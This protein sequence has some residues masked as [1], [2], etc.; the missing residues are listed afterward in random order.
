MAIN[1]TEAIVL[2]KQDFRETSLIAHFYTRDFGKVSGLLKGIRTEPTK[3]ASSVEPFSFNEIIYYQKRNSA[4]HLV[5]Q[6]DV[7]ENF[8]QLRQSLIKSAIASLMMELL[9]AVMGQEDKNVEVFDLALAS[10]KELDKT[11]QPEKIMMIFKIKMLSLSGFQPH[12][13]SCLACG[14]R[15]LDQA[16]F[17][18]AQG[19]LLCSRCFGKDSKARSIFRGTTAT[20]LHIQKNDFCVNLNLGMNPQIKKEL[21]VILNSFINFH[22]E[23]ELKSQRV[24]NDLAVPV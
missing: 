10:L 2:K 11:Y 3:F 15:I 20:L 12:F 23:K 22:L 8:A 21:E 4:L 1:R 14:G 6:C 24:L 19:G 5:S 16:K 13:E 17:S 7:K 9:G 18:L